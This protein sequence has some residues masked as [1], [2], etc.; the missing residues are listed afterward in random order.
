MGSGHVAAHE[1]MR[2]HSRPM[3]FLDRLGRLLDDTVLL[4]EEA[5]AELD[6]ADR[7]LSSGDAAAARDVL[8]RLLY[9]RPNLSRARAAL[10]EAHHRLGDHAA[11][12]TE[13][14]AARE[15]DEGDETLAVQH[16]RLALAAGEASEAVDAAR[17]AV[18]WL[19]RAG[20]APLAE[21]L[22]LYARAELA[23][24]RPDRAAREARKALAVVAD[25][26]DALAVLLEAQA[27]AH[28]AAGA[29]VTLRRLRAVG[30]V[31][32]LAPDVAERLATLAWDAGVPATDAL[33]ETIERA[34]AERRGQAVALL[35][36]IRLREGR[37]GDAEELA[38]RAVA[39]AGGA[40][41]LRVRA[42]VALVR[43]DAD[44]A[45]DAMEAAW[46]ASGDPADLDEAIRVAPAGELTLAS[47]ARA[48]ALARLAEARAS[49]PSAEPSSAAF[50]A[51]AVASLA[52]GDRRRA[53]ELLSGLAADVR[54]PRVAV[55]RARLALRD[56]NGGAAL[57]AL[58]VAVRPDDG[59]SAALAALRGAALKGVFLR[60][61]D[62]DGA[63]SLDIA[64]AL[65][66]VASLARDAGADAEVARARWLREELDRPLLVAV[67]GEFNAGKSTFINALVGADVA[68]MGILPTTATLNV[69]RDGVER[70]VRVVRRDG[71]TRDGDFAA[72][73]AILGD[74]EAEGRSVARVEILAPID[75]LRRVWILDTPGLNALDAEHRAL[76]ERAMEEADVV[77]WIFDA[78]QA[79]KDTER[80]AL[81]KLHAARVPVLPVL[82]KA[83][84]LDEN[85]L[86]EVVARAA[87]ELLAI[88]GRDGPS[89]LTIVSAR[90]ALEGRLKGDDEKLARS[91]WSTMESVLETHVFGRSVEL[92]RRASLARLATLADAT[93]RSVG[94]SA[95]HHLG[96]LRA[97]DE[98]EP[99]LARALAVLV[100]RARNVEKP[101]H[102]ALATA[103][104]RLS[105]EIV[106]TARPRRHALDKNALGP[107]DVAFLRDYAEDALE[108]AAPA[109]V[110]V[111]A[112]ETAGKGA[113]A[114]LAALLAARGVAADPV[115]SWTRE[116]EAQVARVLAFQ[117]GVLWTALDRWVLEELP[118]AAL[119]ETDV[120]TRL[121]RWE[122]DLG[123]EL[124]APLADAVDRVGIAIRAARDRRASELDRAIA[125]RRTATTGLLDALVALVE[126]Q[127]ELVAARR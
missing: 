48:D 89:E 119:S 9:A 16:A 57:D 66:R 67:M 62:G 50:G 86:A 102:E 34:A 24:G 121:L 33:V 118:R 52:R 107:E 103:F 7:L 23:R 29:T 17:D 36:A 127:P 51:W 30:L 94:A 6:E 39:S 58:D 21:A 56:G 64:A 87:P 28:D 22:L 99:Q 114:D 117:R 69:L 95:E 5:R 32:S 75:V 79:G 105:A 104:G 18:R 74:A 47:G 96:E 90:L 3:G 54:E 101:A 84:R 44:V 49:I 109:L 80:R 45:R 126:E 110:A 72:L 97:L 92:K 113:L 27:R 123:R 25:A 81:D 116:V 60:S 26:P 15:L 61:T 83:D 93:R 100:A 2:V 4:P 53:E 70:R 125:R 71:S 120:A 1:A 68:P 124:A 13:A 31:A 20:G 115:A 11:A 76:A 59:T 111:V 19:V 112:G 108:R 106:A 14:R 78:G 42:A 77:L 63:A 73:R 41:A 55:A 88:S 35:A 122:V 46:A 37:I 65:D 38:V 85:E 40:R 10:A 91:R 12:L 8:I 43:G 98:V 82:N